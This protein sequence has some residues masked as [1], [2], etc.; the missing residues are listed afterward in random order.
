MRLSLQAVNRVNYGQ[1]NDRMNAFAG[2][3]SAI[4]AMDGE[5][6][7]FQVKGGNSVLF[8]AMLE[9]ACVRRVRPGMQREAET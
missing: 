5:S 7:L 9:D 4:A 6:A 8:E 2:L 3:V 1:T